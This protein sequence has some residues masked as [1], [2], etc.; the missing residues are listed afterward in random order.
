[1]P[2]NNN[3][4]SSKNPSPKGGRI[5]DLKKIAQEK[6][7][8]IS[9]RSQKP[10]IETKIPVVNEPEDKTVFW[11]SASDEVK[12]QKSLLWYLVIG[13]ITMALIVFAI[14]QKNWLFLMFIILAIA[15]YIASATNKDSKKLYRINQQGITIDE[16][17]FPFKELRGFGVS[18]KRGER[19]LAFETNK[20]SEKYLIVP[21]KKDE[22]KIT[23]FLK[24]HLPKKEYQESFLDT[25]KD[26]L[27]F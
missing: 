13:V 11:W 9:E 12:T 18:E 17:L 27:G 4:N 16:K 8:Q 20:I 19:I 24:K 2:N 10:Q 21:I 14:V 7:I 23:D 22:E 1:M 15:T 26:Y 6:N 5:V 3:S 25:I